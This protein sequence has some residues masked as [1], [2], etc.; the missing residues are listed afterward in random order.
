MRF[1]QS[2][3]RRLVDHHD[4]GYDPGKR[5]RQNPILKTA[6]EALH[7]QIEGLEYK[8]MCQTGPAHEPLF[9]ITVEVNGQCFT[10]EARSKKQAK[11]IAAQNALKS[12]VQFRNPLDA[13]IALGKTS[14]NDATLDFTC[15]DI[16]ELC[17]KTQMVPEIIPVPVM[18]QPEVRS[19]LEPPPMEKQTEIKKS[20]SYSH[21][22]KETAAKT[23]LTKQ[24]AKATVIDKSK[25]TVMSLNEL[26]PGL[27]Y[28][29]IELSS[30]TTTKKFQTTVNIDQTTYEGF[31]PSKKLA[32]Q[33]CAR[34]ALS[35]LYGV[36]F[37][38]IAAP[39]E[40]TWPFADEA[41][42]DNGNTSPHPIPLWQDFSMKQ[43]TADRVG[44]LVQDKFDTLVTN[45]PVASRRKVMAGVVMTRDGN[46]MA[47][48]EVVCVT[49]GTKCI[50]GEH[51]CLSG[52][53]VNDCHAEVL[54]RRCLMRF[55][56]SELEKISQADG[57]VLVSSVLEKSDQGGYRVKGDIRFHLYINTAPCGDAR[58]FSPHADK[59][60]SV[61]EDSDKHANR[62]SR[63]Q[64]R[65][66]IESGEGTIPVSSSDDIQTWD[67]VMQGSRLLTMSCSDKV[68][69][70][71]V[72]G[73]Q[74]ALLSYYIEPIYFYSIVLGSHFH[75]VHML[76]AVT[77]RVKDSLLGLKTPYILRTPKLNLLTSQEVRQP[78]KSPN[79]SLNWTLG[80]E[81]HE[82]LD[83]TKGKLEGMPSRLCKNSLF[84]RW[85]RIARQGVLS[86][87][88]P[89]PPLNDPLASTY[90]VV[91]QSSTDFQNAKC[92][93]FEAFQKAHLGNW[94]KKPMEQDDFEI[95]A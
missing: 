58:I 2:L 39:A 25:N 84:A 69:R 11:Q 27:K 13:Q 78:G 93:L 15:D 21:E 5:R 22:V 82:I 20:M 74:G 83:A 64:L 54:S 92:I 94:M 75:S 49:T 38:P 67:G 81:T 36:S 37:T 10:G 1:N 42:N 45:N 29:S 87:R 50:N 79:H 59:G 51:L 65:T 89:L 80:D 56:Y 53:A 7:E 19:T 40:G 35:S 55:L 66:K 57:D 71:N 95:V 52:K 77:S 72:V 33:A 28:V 86:S 32:K 17:S 68:C 46:Q 26:K 88:T 63:G 6:C 48:L 73:V 18:E 4:Y 70:W 23:E 62:R 43:E 30:T 60:S 16:A 12:I 76:R 91:K 3:K 24:T 44:K 85:L 47:S 9:I 14:S 90:K 31:G 8:L 61:L 41:K 34:A